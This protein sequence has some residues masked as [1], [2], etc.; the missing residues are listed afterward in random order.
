MRYKW[1]A[2]LVTQAIGVH[3]G[4]TP[5]EHWVKG[6]IWSSRKCFPETS[7]LS[8]TRPSSGNTVS[9]GQRGFLFSWSWF[10]SWIFLTLA[11]LPFFSGVL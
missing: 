5:E 2:S 7:S 6:D 4:P 3:C 1:G 8:D 10:S 11:R 9:V